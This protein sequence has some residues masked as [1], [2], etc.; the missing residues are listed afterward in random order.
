V[1]H[2]RDQLVIRQGV[3]AED[4]RIPTTAGIAGA[5]YQDGKVGSRFFPPDK[6]D[7][8]NPITS[9]QALNIPDP[10]KDPRFNKETDKKTGKS[11]SL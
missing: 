7:A 10:Y 6:L 4:I 8:A 11:F 3:G 5:V 9:V 2:I 1:D